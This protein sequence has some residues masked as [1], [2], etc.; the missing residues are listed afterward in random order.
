MVLRNNLFHIF[1]AAKGMNRLGESNLPYKYNWT[2][3]FDLIK[4]FL[5]RHIHKFDHICH[6]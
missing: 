5:K 6:N 3:L 1:G 2:F 4:S